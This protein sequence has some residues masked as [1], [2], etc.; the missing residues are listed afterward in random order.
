MDPAPVAGFG[1]AAAVGLGL[2]IP[3]GAAS[4]AAAWH[5][6][7]PGG[8][9]Q[10]DRENFSVVVRVRPPLERELALPEF[11]NVLSVDGTGEVTL[12]EL[13]P[14]PVSYERG[15]A[16]A[17][18][19][20]NH[21]FTFDRVYDRH[22]SQPEVYA[23]T[24]R[25]SVLSMLQG[26]N[27]TVLAYGP[28]GSGK[29]YTM[30][31]PGMQTHGATCTAASGIIP[32]SMDEIFQHIRHYRGPQA[33]FLVRASYLQIYNEV[34]SD[35]LKPDRSHLTIR[36][37]KRRGIFVEGLSEWLCKSPSEVHTL[38]ERGS[39]AR[40]TAQTAANDASS[41]SHAVF[42]VIVEQSET[43]ADEDD[44]GNAADQAAGGVV[45]TTPANF[46]QGRQRVRVGRL[47]LVDLAGSERPRLTG[48]V[49]QRLEETKKI[50][51][52]LS[53]LGNVISALTEKRPR[54]HIPYRDSKLTRLLEDSLGG[55]CRTTLMAMVSPASE[56]FGET[57]STLKFAHRAKAI[58]NT[59]QVNEDVDQRT[60]L[61]RYEAELK[62][63]REELR[64]RSQNVVDKRQLL[65]V[66]EDRRRAEEDFAAAV[67]ALEGR[68][69]ELENEKAQK[70]QL[71]ERI[72]QMSSQMLVGGHRQQDYQ[73]ITSD[74]ER[75][76]SEYASKLSELE[77][78][79]CTI[80]EDKAQ[81]GRYK[82]LLLKQRDIM[83]ALTQRL[84][85]RDETIIALQDDIDGAERRV[86][87]LEEQLDRRRAQLLA[88][89]RQTVGAAVAIGGGGT[90]SAES[91]TVSEMLQY[92]P[93][94]VAFNMRRGA[95]A[96]NGGVGQSITMLSAEEK[97][98]ELSA[99]LDSQRQ[100]NHRL[101]LE[102]EDQEHLPLKPGRG[103]PGAAASSAFASSPQRDRGAAEGLLE[104]IS[105][106]LSEMAGPSE[107]K[108]VVMQDLETLRR[109]ALPG[110]A[111]MSMGNG[112][113]HHTIPDGA[114]SAN[115]GRGP[116]DVDSFMQKVLGS[117]RGSVG[118]GPD[119]ADFADDASPSPAGSTSTP[120]AAGR[121]AA[122]RQHPMLPVQGHQFQP[123]PRGAAALGMGSGGA[124]G[125]YSHD[126]GSTVGG[127]ASATPR[128]QG[129]H[130]RRAASSERQLSASLSGA[131]GS[132][133]SSDGATSRPRSVGPFPRGQATSERPLTVRS[134]HSHGGGGTRASSVGS[135]S[136]TSYASQ[137]GGGSSSL[138]SN[139]VAASKVAGFSSS[140]PS[141]ARAQAA[142]PASAGGTP[143]SHMHGDAF[144]NG[145][146][147]GSG[148]QA[149]PTG[150]VGSLVGGSLSE[151]LS[152]FMP[153]SQDAL[154]RSASSGRPAA[155]GGGGVAATTSHA[156]AWRG[157][158][159]R[160]SMQPLS[161]PWGG[162]AGSGGA[163]AEAPLATP[164]PRN[165]QGSALPP[166]TAAALASSERGGSAAAAAAANPAEALRREAQKSVDAL[167]ARRRAEL[168]QQRKAAQAAAGV[169]SL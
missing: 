32:R 110:G 15:G 49:G 85:E 152:G 65:E 41:R 143:T 78:E 3:N 161:S 18:V 38:M 8:E 148:P 133:A 108:A 27:A 124:S 68:S 52:S 33:R 4:A 47:N 51:Q 163:P 155:S 126:S 26:Y 156:A 106:S 134:R 103:G 43:V 105:G 71:E 25:A 22:T 42:M 125:A 39:T 69:R 168:A 109:L 79:R 59:P 140:T 30:E 36:E 112:G 45:I 128:A 118:R 67:N 107:L 169:D 136:T 31:G 34:I 1:E 167:L 66:E 70:R 50:N 54:Q 29:T 2:S 40:A 154:R 135:V 120:A 86:G 127:S 83:I 5:R 77:R 139:A 160:G 90:G 19:I 81:V 76:C 7:A 24:A 48:A 64:Q 115:G 145:S 146:D 144:A 151:L 61:R 100:E 138:K 130:G 95:G 14:D 117:M 119:G 132:S 98:A 102:L 111:H 28:T 37:E 142:R 116:Q 92:P 149:S 129:L 55:N 88:A 13:V 141:R 56:A 63:L 94:N 114:M 158:P 153:P 97:I 20:A 82:Q 113:R 72:R 23:G 62:A 16:G 60:L 58:R 46:R 101:V 157:T 89:E 10:D 75:M 123:N 6:G 11:Q 122:A 53:T 150:S 99:L 35:L 74:A 165:W 131:A 137:W 17:R 96:G 80:E 147:A 21:L 93:E 87:E 73:G 84:H 166:A 164:P 12:H 104:R 159:T 162:G 91:A 57:L 9:E 44:A 121:G